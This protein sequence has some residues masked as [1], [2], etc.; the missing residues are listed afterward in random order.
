LLTIKRDDKDSERTWNTCLAL[1]VSKKTGKP[2][3]PRKPEKNNWKNQTEKNR[4]NRLNFWKN[5]PVRFG[6]GFIRKKPSR[7]EPKPT[8]NRKKTRAKPDKPS[9][10]RAKPKKPSQTEKNRAKTEKTEPK[11]EKPSQTGLN[12]F[13]P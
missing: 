10:N 6:F 1:G 9:Q 11:L 4:L 3:K 8:K 13:L 5:R 12:R 2:I 7:T